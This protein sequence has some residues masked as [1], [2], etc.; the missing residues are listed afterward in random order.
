MTQLA[1]SE[2]N[3][4]RDWRVLSAVVDDAAGDVRLAALEHF[5]TLALYDSALLS[6]PVNTQPTQPVPPVASVR[7]FPNE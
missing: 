2:F 3:A 7:P 5:P 4:P 6:K 1:R